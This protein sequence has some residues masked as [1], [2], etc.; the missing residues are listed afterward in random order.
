MNKKW[1]S[2]SRLRS[3]SVS[4][5]L[6]LFLLHILPGSPPNP[7]LHSP[8]PQSQTVRN[9]FI[10]SGR[11]PVEVKRA[12]PVPRLTPLSFFMA[13]LVA[14]PSLRWIMRR[15]YYLPPPGLC[16]GRPWPYR[17][18]ILPRRS[19]THKR[20]IYSATSASNMTPLWIFELYSHP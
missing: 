20:L 3:G 10:G 18:I 2:P 14:E 15:N 8:H 17:P 4:P 16:S 5:P 6:F 9:K 19:L 1:T 12:S 13:H 7:L 11:M